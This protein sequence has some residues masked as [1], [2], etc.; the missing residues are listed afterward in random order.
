MKKVTLHTLWNF[1]KGSKQP[2]EAWTFMKW[3]TGK[4][5]QL[6]M[7]RTGLIPTNMEARKSWM[8]DRDSYLYPYVE[9]TAEAFL[10]PPVKNWGK[11]EQVY[12]VYLSKIFLGE[13]SVKEGLDRAA[14]EIDMLLADTDSEHK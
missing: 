5:A 1:K 2:A 4:E 10:R 13:L 7:A 14:S 6:V 12:I 9:A 11:I 8:V 3:M